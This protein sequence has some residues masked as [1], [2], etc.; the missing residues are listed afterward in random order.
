MVVLC[1]LLAILLTGCVPL[2]VLDILEELHTADTIDYGLPE[3]PEVQEEVRAE[4]TENP[5]DS[6]LFLGTWRLEKIA[7]RVQ[8]IGE[9]HAEFEIMRIFRMKI[10]K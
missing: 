6:Y 9:F 10:W 7:I 4:G 8:H 3:T 1:V 5:V 2:E